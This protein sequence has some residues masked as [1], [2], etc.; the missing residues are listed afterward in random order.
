VRAVP[1]VPGLLSGGRR[2]MSYI[3]SSKP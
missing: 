3:L 1:S 2:V